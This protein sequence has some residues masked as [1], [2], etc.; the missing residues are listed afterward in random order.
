LVHEREF[1]MPYPLPDERGLTNTEQAQLD[2]EHIRAE[3]ADIP[4]TI[5]EAAGRGDTARIIELAN[6]ATTL[7]WALSEA[8]TR[9]GVGRTIQALRTKELPAADEQKVIA[10]FGQTKRDFERWVL[11]YSS[12]HKQLETSMRLILDA[13]Q[14]CQRQ[15]DGLED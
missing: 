3:L 14:E 5:V 8:T 4:G 6:H 1:S 9:Y 10:D 12:R 11:E 15:I 13:L 2:M 7:D